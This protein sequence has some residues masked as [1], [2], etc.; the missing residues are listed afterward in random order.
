M[1]CKYFYGQLG[2]GFSL[3]VGAHELMRLWFKVD[4][5]SE[6]PLTKLEAEN[7]CQKV[8]DYLNKEHPLTDADAEVYGDSD[9]AIERIDIMNKLANDEISEEEK[10]ELKAKMFLE[11]MLRKCAEEDC[12]CGD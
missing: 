1:A 11:M 6:S 12:G 10:E 8:V 9:E 2:N 7:I 4:G 3:G 5:E